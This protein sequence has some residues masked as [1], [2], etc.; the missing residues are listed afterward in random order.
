MESCSSWKFLQIRIIKTNEILRNLLFWVVTGI[1]LI[2]IFKAISQWTQTLELSHT[3][4]FTLDSLLLLPEIT[5]IR[6]FYWGKVGIRVIQDRCKILVRALW[7]VFQSRS[8]RNCAPSRIRSL[9]HQSTEAMTHTCV[10]SPV[11]RLLTGNLNFLSNW[12]QT[13]ASNSNFMKS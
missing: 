9:L 1:F 12:K 2:L 7:T 5:V 10:L 13:I 11:T 3:F 4:H 6:G 8:V